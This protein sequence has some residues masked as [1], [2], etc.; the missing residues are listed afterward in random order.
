M[1]TRKPGHGTWQQPSSVEATCRVARRSCR[2]SRRFWV[3][4]FFHSTPRKAGRST[5]S[6]RPCASP[7]LPQIDDNGKVEA[8]WRAPVKLWECWDDVLR[9]K[10]RKEDWRRS[11]VSSLLEAGTANRL[12]QLIYEKSRFQVPLGMLWLDGEDADR[13]ENL[14]AKEVSI[15]WAVMVWY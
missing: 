13:P 12:G 8:T 10:D 7:G 3:C 1:A 14:A 9:R 11:F 6:F 15:S 2:I 4:R 5:S